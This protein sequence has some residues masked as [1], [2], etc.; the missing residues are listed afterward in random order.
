MLL[1]LL[2]IIR[3]L[4]NN[5]SKNVSRLKISPITTNPLD[6]PATTGREDASHCLCIKIGC[7][8]EDFIEVT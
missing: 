3:P 2:I 4:Q 8:I 5:P 6:N 1:F 7:K